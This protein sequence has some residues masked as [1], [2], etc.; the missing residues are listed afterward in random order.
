MWTFLCGL[1]KG[2]TKDRYERITNQS[3]NG[4]KKIEYLCKNCD[5]IMKRETYTKRAWGF[6]LTAEEYF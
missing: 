3:Q 1:I 4:T 5:K 6:E 2:H